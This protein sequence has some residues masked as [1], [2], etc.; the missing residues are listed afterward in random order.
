MATKTKGNLL[1]GFI[2]VALGIVALL[3]QWLPDTLGENLGQ[4]LLLGLGVIFLAVGVAT[5]ESGWF[6]PGGI[7]S[8][9]G[10]GVLLVSSPLAARLG[11][12]EGGWFLL[13]FAGGWFLIPLLTAIFAEETHWWALIP[14]G[15]I[16]VVGLAVLYGGL[17][18]SALE[19]AGRLWPLAL[20]IGGALLLWKSRRPAIVGAEKPVEKQA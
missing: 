15:I 7:L 14:G 8:G 18:L 19:W 11:G 6:I 4:F 5:R 3:F 20:I 1:T 12:D 9:L 17:F 13:A 10:A 2:L 16:A